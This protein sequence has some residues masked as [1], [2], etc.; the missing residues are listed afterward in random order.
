MSILRCDKVNMR[1]GALVAVNS[2]S[3]EV[4]K[5]EIFGIA[6]PNGAGKSTLFNVISGFYQGS[7]DIYFEDVNISK[8][9]PHQICRLGIAR[10]FQLPQLFQSL[11]VYDNVRIGAHFGIEGPHDDIEIINMDLDLWTTGNKNPD[12]TKNKF[13]TA[14]KDFAREGYIGFQDHGHPVWYSNVRIKEL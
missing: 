9:R 1:F 6:G 2:L 14:L 10:T 12:G 11:S 13:K 7:G 4:E 5:G 8:M 3:F